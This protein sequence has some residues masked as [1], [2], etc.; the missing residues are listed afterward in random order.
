MFVLLSARVYTGR[1]SDA[2]AVDVECYAGSRGE[3][4][5][6]RFKLGDRLAEVEAVVARWQTPE[7]RFKDF[8]R[9]AGWIRSRSE[10]V[11]NDRA[12]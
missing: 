2:L 7:F 6:R 1:V 4:A 12:A 8:Q 11:P 9:S 3:E 5:P 10:D